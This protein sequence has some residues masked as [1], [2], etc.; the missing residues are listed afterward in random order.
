MK[1][2]N[3]LWLQISKKIKIQLI[4]LI[5]LMIFVSFAE[6]LSI[7]AVLPFLGVLT[8]PEKV[9]NLEIIK[10]I[11]YYFNLKSPND[12]I[13]PL[14]LIFAFSAILAG[15]SR[16][17]LIWFQTSIGYKIGVN[18]SVLIFRRTIF[19]PYSTHTSMNSSN[20]IA[21]ITN[22]ID[23]VIE[24]TLI[25][26]LLIL[27]SSIIFISIFSILIFINPLIAILASTLFAFIYS[28]LLILSKQSME[29]NSFIVSRKLNEVAKSIQEALGGIREIIID[30]TQET[31]CDIHENAEIPL[32]KAR[33]SIVIASQ[34]PRFAIE[35]I[36]MVFIAL[37]AYFISERSIG[38]ADAIPLLGT[39][40]LGAHRLLPVLQLIYFS[41][42]NLRGGKQS[43]LDV[44]NLLEQ[45]VFKEK[46]N[47]KIK[48]M[49]FKDNIQFKD[50]SFS[51]AENNNNVLKNINLS[52]KKGTK[53][54]LVGKTGC[55]KSTLID[56]LMGLLKPSKGEILIDGKGL[57]SEN[58]RSWQLHISHVPQSIFLSDS[59]IQQNIAFSAKKE[60]I[61]LD[62]VVNS[63][64]KAQIHEPIQSMKLKYNSIVGERGIKLSGGQ[65]QRIGIARALYKNMD[66]IILDEATSALDLK[67]ERKVME[68]INKISEDITI[69][70]VAHRLSTLTEYDQILELKDGNLVFHK[71]VDE[72]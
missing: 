23:S 28:I 43:L 64:I 65:R 58:I 56:I 7:G 39:L 61:K 9:Y 72:L 42:T 12:L 53:I 69:V 46:Y 26:I 18:L 66:I 5:I 1:N 8:S 40:A 48:P 30:G 38:L 34:T 21:S 71:S 67:T 22:K 6:V 57:T 14:T 62:Q 59:T 25:P 17:I 13:L 32:K 24:Q 37:L 70:V 10:P 16:L 20:I 27:S 55:G 45:P 33:S 2:Y 47:S 36:G 19:Q 52:I 44:L 41:F 4:F 68:A 50:V 31:Y 54:G 35:A 11:I 60:L 63:A 15:A 49:L 29:K 51:Y 3:R